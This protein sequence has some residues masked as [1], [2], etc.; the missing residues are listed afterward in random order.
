[1]NTKKFADD[2]GIYRLDSMNQEVDRVSLFQRTNFSWDATFGVWNYRILSAHTRTPHRLFLN[3]IYSSSAVKIAQKNDTVNATLKSI[4]LSNIG[5]QFG[6]IMRFANNFSFQ[7]NASLFGQTV[8]NASGLISNSRSKIFYQV[9]GLLTYHFPD[10]LS[11][12]FLRGIYNGLLQP[13]GK[14]G[15]FNQLQIGYNLDIGDF[16]SKVKKQ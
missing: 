9:D 10:Q 14:K 15:V 16:I 13:E 5:G 12:L 3:F 8:S 7:T 1:M 4:T 6:F 2:N 11:T